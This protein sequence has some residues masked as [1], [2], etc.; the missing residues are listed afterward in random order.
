MFVGVTRRRARRPGKSSF[1]NFGMEIVVE[2]VIG[3]KAWS[4]WS[5]RPWLVLMRAGAPFRETLI[6]L[7]QEN[8]QSGAAIRGHSPSGLVPAFKDGDLTIWD[9]LAIC[10]YLAEQFEGLWP[11]DPTARALAR[12][13]TAEMHAGFAALRRE[14]PMDLAATPAAPGS[15]AISEAAA[16]NI[17]RIVTL[18]N[19][20]LSRFD[21]AFLA[22]D[23]SI[24]DAFFTPVATRFRTYGVRLAEYGDHGAAQ[25]YSE[26]LL[27]T[28]EFLAWEE[29]T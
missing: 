11:I 23:W 25:A 9:S 21:G 14:H 6:Q 18:W 28:P 26:R 29:E 27:S 3:T 22:G 13:A 4:T 10:E 8:D 24:A 5:M 1:R 20:M 16:G 19:E 2:L 15:V 17:L 7:R 12:A